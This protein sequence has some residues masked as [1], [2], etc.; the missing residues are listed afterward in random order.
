[1]FWIIFISSYCI[2]TTVFYNVSSMKAGHNI[3]TQYTLSKH[4]PNERRNCHVVEM[5]TTVKCQHR[6]LSISP[7]LRICVIQHSVYFFALKQ[8]FSTGVVLTPLR[9]IWKQGDMVRVSHDW[10][11]PQWHLVGRSQG[12]WIFYSAW[13]SPI[14]YIK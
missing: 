1:M 14:Q 10:G 6:D 9:G 7:F 4:I 13:T 5:S 8:L 2:F 3:G 12:S 11:Q